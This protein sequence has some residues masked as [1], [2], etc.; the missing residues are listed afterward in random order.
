MRLRVAEA[1]TWTVA[2]ILNLAIVYGVICAIHR[3]F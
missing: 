3:W 2:M 1:I